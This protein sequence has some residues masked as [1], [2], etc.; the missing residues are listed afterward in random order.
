[1]IKLAPAEKMM[2]SGQKIVLSKMANDDLLDRR[3]LNSAARFALEEKLRGRMQIPSD[4]K[5]VAH[6][7]NEANQFYIE[8]NY[9]FDL[10]N[11][12]LVPS[13]ETR[14]GP[15]EL[16]AEIF[17]A[18]ADMVFA[19]KHMSEIV[20]S[21]TRARMLQAKFD[22]M[23]MRREG[24]QKDLELFQNF[25]FESKNLRGAINKGERTFSEF[26]NLL[27]ESRKF[28]DWLKGASPEKGLLKEYYDAVT[29]QGWLDKLPNK[30]ARFGL[31]TGAG[32][33]LGFI[34]GGLAAAA[35]GIA[36]GAADTFLLDRVIRGWRPN[37]FV[38]EDLK[39]FVVGS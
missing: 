24:S 23:N 2:M 19:S 3:Y 37:Q 32:I 1:L 9:N 35:G 27:D 7:A 13:P 28:K 38:E 21:P 10:I 17:E 30:S 25:H 6:I 39:T 5:F 34:T 18:R 14:F 26:L 29:K 33:A 31:M 8:T 11:Q 12:N 15:A 4:W 20:T 22:L 36:L 16:L